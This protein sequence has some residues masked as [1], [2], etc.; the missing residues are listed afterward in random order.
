VTIITRVSRAPPAKLREDLVQQTQ[1]FKQRHALIVKGIEQ[2]QEVEGARTLT[3]SPLH[4]VKG[5]TL[6]FAEGRRGGGGEKG[7]VG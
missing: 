1:R 7:L 2:P 4:S 5:L 3:P 6:A